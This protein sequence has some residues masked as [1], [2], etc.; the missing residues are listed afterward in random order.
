MLDD[1]RPLWQRRADANIYWPAFGPASRLARWWHAL[2]RLGT[3]ILIAL[4][5]TLTRGVR[6][7]S[8]RLPEP[9]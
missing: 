5:D 2:R 1:D 7:V 4:I 9:K 8:D 6:W 3:R